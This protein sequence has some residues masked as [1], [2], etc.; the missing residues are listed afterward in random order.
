MGGDGV[1]SCILRKVSFD[2]IVGPSWSG[3]TDGSLPDGTPIRLDKR[4][5]LQANNLPGLQGLQA[6]KLTK[7]SLNSLV[8]PQGGRRTLLIAF[9]TSFHILRLAVMDR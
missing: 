5:T 9:S 6:T 8:G 3:G 1:G 7:L 2:L 4:I